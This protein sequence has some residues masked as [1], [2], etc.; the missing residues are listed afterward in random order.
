MGILQVPSYKSYWSQEFRC[1][2]VADIMPYIRYQELFRCL[3]FVN[4]DS[5]NA[6]DKLANGTRRVCEDRI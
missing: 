3:H 1:P 2:R 6:Q 5:I 4:N